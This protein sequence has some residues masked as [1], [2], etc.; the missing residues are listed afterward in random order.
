MIDTRWSFGPEDLE[1]E[2]EEAE[3]ARSLAEW[4][5]L[6]IAAEFVEDEKLPTHARR[7]NSL[8]NLAGLIA[9]GC[10]L[11]LGFVLVGIGLAGVF[12]SR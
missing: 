4:E 5:S 6:G 3:E 7:Y 2:E 12:E 8:W 11:A 1:P 9:L 10:V